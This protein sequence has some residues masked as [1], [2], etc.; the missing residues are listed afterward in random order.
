M[1][2]TRV[3]LLAYIAAV[4][5][6]AAAQGNI[7]GN[8]N[9]NYNIVSI[10][11]LFPHRARVS[12]TRRLRSGQDC[13]TR[14]GNSRRSSGNLIHPIIQPFHQVSGCAVF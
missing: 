9:G 10:S 11:P 14:Q 13:I 5:A 2:A 7:N 3:L 6:Y 8:G 12:R 4:L 1:R